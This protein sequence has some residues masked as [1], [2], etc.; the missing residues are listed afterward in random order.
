MTRHTGSRALGRQAEARALEFL[1]H[2]GLHCL[3]R[4]FHT[5][6][7]EIDLIMEDSGDIVFV[8]VRQRATKRYGG[9]LESV[10]LVKQRRLIAAARYYLLAYAPNAACR[11]DVV[12]LDG[13]H[14][15]EWIRD[16][17]QVTA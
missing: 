13:Q 17:F 7:G 9:A 6:A 11:F 12:A 4:N 3:H 1:C 2:R 16:A 8:E 10:T 15:I 14:G 5:R